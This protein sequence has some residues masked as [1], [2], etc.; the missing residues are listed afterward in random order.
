MVA[1]KFGFLEKKG[2]DIFGRNKLFA[3]R[4]RWDSLKSMAENV[5]NTAK[6]YETAFNGIKSSIENK[7]DFQQV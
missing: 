6:E 4:I 3:P 7:A 2:F 1:R 5:K